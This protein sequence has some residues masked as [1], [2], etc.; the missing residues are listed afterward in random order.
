FEVRHRSEHCRSKL[1]VS[2]TPREGVIRLHYRKLEKRPKTFVPARPSFGC[3]CVKEGQVEDIRSPG[4][5]RGQFWRP[6]GHSQAMQE[7]LGPIATPRRRWNIRH[8]HSMTERTVR[9][10]GYRCART[11]ANRPSQALTANCDEHL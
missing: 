5:Q 3:R 7:L 6:S 9:N 11:A 2:I 4:R 10:E 1:D 8:P